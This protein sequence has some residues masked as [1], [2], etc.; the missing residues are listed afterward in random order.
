MGGPAVVASRTAPPLATPSPCAV[1]GAPAG[2]PRPMEASTGQPSACKGGPT[3]R[4]YAHSPPTALCR[5]AQAAR[6]PWRHDPIDVGAVHHPGAVQVLAPER[7]RV[8]SHVA[9]AL[10]IQTGE[11]GRRFPTR[12]VEP[13][14]AKRK[15]IQR[16]YLHPQ[17][18]DRPAG[19]P[20]HRGAT[21]ARRC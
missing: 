15:L 20:G 14:R 1:P 4:T 12:L 2:A 5:A 11:F 19:L 6:R 18:T 8:C 3:D 10:V 13:G 16:D 17:L 7:G 9:C 21:G